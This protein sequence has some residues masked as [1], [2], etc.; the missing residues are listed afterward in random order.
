MERI[1]EPYNLYDIYGKDTIIFED[2]Q[3]KLLCTF[4]PVDEI[5]NFARDIN[6]QYNILYNKL[7]VL[8]V[9]NTNQYVCT[10]NVDTPNIT[11]IPENTILVHRKKHT[12]T[13]YTINALNELI[14]SLNEGIVDPTYQINWN[15][16][17]DTLILT[18]QNELKFLRTQI[19]KI[20][21]F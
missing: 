15:H 16:Y 2:M 8:Y 5:N 10:Y 7:F 9:K 11:T 20:I 4:V 13:L 18:Q 12:R 19:H 14:K 17:K 1:T 3:N 6:T 21:E